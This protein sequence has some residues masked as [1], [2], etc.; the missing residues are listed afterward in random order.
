MNSTCKQF[1]VSLL[2]SILAIALIACS[3]APQPVL[4]EQ[5]EEQVE[6]QADSATTDNAEP[7]A[8]EAAP[9]V[10][11]LELARDID[12]Q[13]VAS[14]LDRDDVFL[15]DVREVW[16]HEEANIAGN[17]L[18]PTGSVADRLAEIPHRPRSDRLL[19]QRRT[20]R[21]GDSFPRRA[22]I[23]Q[24]PQYVGRN[25]GLGECWA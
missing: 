9:E 20:Q 5:A 25:R 1:S 8:A 18:I 12:V 10:A 6:E 19:P 3:P 23:H 4:E 16:E 22:R 11:S 14:V 17:T 7:A 2:L 24:H 15:L 21:T 13:T